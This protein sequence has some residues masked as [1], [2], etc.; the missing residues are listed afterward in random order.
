MTKAPS[1]YW[2]WLGEN[3][4]HII[5]ALG[6]VKKGAEVSKKAG[7]MWKALPDAQKLPYLERSNKLKE[8]V[9]A[10]KPAKEEKKNKVVKEV[11]GNRK[12]PMTPVFAYIQEKRAEISAMP[13]VKGL[14]E[15][16]K[17][18]A[19]L[20]KALPAAEQEARRK[21]YDDE[22]KAFTEW[23]ESSEGKEVLAQKKSIVS[24]IKA[25]KQEKLDKKQAKID[26]KEAKEAKAAGGDE[27]AAYVEKK[28]ASIASPPKKKRAS[29]A[30]PAK[31][32]AAKRGRASKVVEPTTSIFIDPELLKEAKEIGYESSLKNLSARKE[33]V[34]S[35]K[36]PKEM[37]EALKTANGLV[38]AA[39]YV[40][41]GA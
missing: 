13:G 40:L 8:E 7:E 32:P 15:I 19:E 16:A 3:R 36:S 23:K 22:M 26:R 31:Q 25:V 20:Y 12:K 38:N 39:K 35:G 28:R 33:I 27:L 6:G 24:E 18:G 21:K 34:D 14:G 2:I 11:E 41:L 37:L 10:K 4:E 30:S 9:A 29:I 17:K 5:K 1:G